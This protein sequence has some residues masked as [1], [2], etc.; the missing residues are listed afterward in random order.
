MRHLE[1]MAKI[2]LATGMMV[3]YAYAIEFFIAWYSGNPYERFAFLNRAFGPYAW[4]Y[5]TMVSC[6]VL[7]PQLFWFEE[8]AHATRWLL[9]RRVDPAS[10]SACGSSASSS[11]SPRC[12]ATS[13]PSS[14]GYVHAD[15]GSTC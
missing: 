5:W 14:W 8:G 11:S 4:A 2:I 9:L 15:A 12:T 7:A 6:N 13:C 10:T 1:N 3:G